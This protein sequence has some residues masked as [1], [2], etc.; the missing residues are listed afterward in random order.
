[1]RALFIIYLVVIIGG[2]GYF[3]LLGALHT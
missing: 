2:L 3:I 1:M